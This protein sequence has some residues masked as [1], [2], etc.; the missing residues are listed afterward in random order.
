MCRCS[1]KEQ[2]LQEIMHQLDVERGPNSCHEEKQPPT[3]E[4]E[5]LQVLLRTERRKSA[6]F[7]LQVDFIHCFE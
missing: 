6:N 5:D 1:E 3:E 7:E 2:E 4:T